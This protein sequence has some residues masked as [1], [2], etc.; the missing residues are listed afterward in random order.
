MNSKD[1][2]K[3]LSVIYSKEN[4]KVMEKALDEFKPDI[5]HVNNF[6]RQLTA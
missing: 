1:V 5:V 3:A 6:Q 2:T 4:K